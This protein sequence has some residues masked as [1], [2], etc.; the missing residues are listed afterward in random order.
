MGC[1]GGTLPVH[2]AIV[3]G[4]SSF[5]RSND[6]DVSVGCRSITDASDVVVSLMQFS[7]RSTTSSLHPLT[8][9]KSASSESALEMLSFVSATKLGTNLTITGSPI[10]HIFGGGALRRISSVV[11]RLRGVNLNVLVLVEF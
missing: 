7:R 3:C 8:I 2:A 1:G 9:A 4:V 11:K 10:C 6:N 5:N